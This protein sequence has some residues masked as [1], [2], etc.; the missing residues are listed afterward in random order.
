MPAD[1]WSGQPDTGEVGDE[2]AVDVMDLRPRLRPAQLSAYD[3]DGRGPRTRTQ[4]R[5]RLALSLSLLLLLAVLLSLVGQHAGVPFLNG[6]TSRPAA[7]TSGSPTSA[8]AVVVV[9]I[10][11]S[12]PTPTIDLATPTTLP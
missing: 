10:A 8:G 12:Q 11:I 7:H 9:S 4:S 6:A 1:E 2:H 3:E 5:H